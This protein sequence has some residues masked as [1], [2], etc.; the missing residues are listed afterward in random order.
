[1]DFWKGLICAYIFIT[2]VYIFFGA[3]VS[4]SDLYHN[5]GHVRLIGHFSQV[6]S[7]YGQYSASNIINVI[8]PVRLQTVNNCINLL[9]FFIAGCKSRHCTLLL[10]C[11]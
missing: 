3:F 4:Q 1:M 10:L 2:V 8:Q 5:S 7:N 9:T 6:Y 11:G